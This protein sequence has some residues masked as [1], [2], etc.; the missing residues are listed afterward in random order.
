MKLNL[1]DELTY[2]NFKDKKF[3]ITYELFEAKIFSS[4][5]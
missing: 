5:K 3:N 1:I 4:E 2:E